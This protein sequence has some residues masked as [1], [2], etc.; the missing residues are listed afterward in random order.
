[1]VDRTFLLIPALLV[2]SGC[3]DIV[4]TDSDEGSTRELRQGS[5]FAVSLPA[6][7]F[8]IAAEPRIEGAFIRYLGRSVQGD[9]GRYVYRFSAEGV[10][11]ADIRIPPDRSH[12]GAPPVFVMRVRIHP[13]PEGHRDLQAQPLPQS[14][15]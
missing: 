9:P 13:A 8:P 10:G 5:S 11:E 15:Y 6:D 4:F 12:P 7:A 1:M 2:L 14:R 3:S